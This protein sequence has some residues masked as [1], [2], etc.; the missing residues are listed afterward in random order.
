LLAQAQQ[1]TPNLSLPG[2]DGKII[3]LSDYRGKVVVLN[4]WATWCTPCSS[5]MHNF[6]NVSVRLRSH[7]NDQ[8]VVVLAASLDDERTRKYIEPFVRSHK[9]T[10]PVLLNAT[11]ADIK[12]FDGS[13]AIPFTVI[14][15]RSGKVSTRIAHPAKEAEL[16]SAIQQAL[17]T[18]KVPG[19]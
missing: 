4:F 12:R 5:E 3:S 1:T 6:V 8:A 10:F 2:R 9:M 14:L 16:E 13:G 18:S 17:Q 19:N 15:D 11:E 7:L